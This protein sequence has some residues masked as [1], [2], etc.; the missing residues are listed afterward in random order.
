VIPIRARS[1]VGAIPLLSNASGRRRRPSFYGRNSKIGF[2]EVV[3]FIEPIFEFLKKEG[4]LRD[5]E[6]VAQPPLR[7]AQAR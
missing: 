6:N 1:S 3:D 5:Q 4:W 7:E 2:S